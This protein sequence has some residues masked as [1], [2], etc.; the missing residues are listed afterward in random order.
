MLIRGDRTSQTVFSMRDSGIRVHIKAA[1]V[2]LLDFQRALPRGHI[3]FGRHHY[4][5]GERLWRFIPS[6]C[7]NGSR[8]LA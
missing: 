2:P 8:G 6:R 3:I 7:G 1:M 5:Q 4:H